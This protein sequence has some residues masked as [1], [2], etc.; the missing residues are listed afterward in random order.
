MNIHGKSKWALKPPYLPSSKERRDRHGWERPRGSF[1]P[2]SDWVRDS[3][4]QWG[5]NSSDCIFGGFT[6]SPPVLPFISA[7]HEQGCL[8]LSVRFK[9]SSVRHMKRGDRCGAC[10]SAGRSCSILPVQLCP[11][12]PTLGKQVQSALCTHLPVLIITLRPRLLTLTFSHRMYS[13]LSFSLFVL[14][15]DELRRERMMLEMAKHRWGYRR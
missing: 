15:S 11:L 9:G 13:S 6:P 8:W 12:G 5:H 1:P 4:P 3:L 2:A 7:D 14:K 10:P